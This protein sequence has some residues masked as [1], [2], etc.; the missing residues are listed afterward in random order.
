MQI[1]AGQNA[2]CS[3]NLS[4]LT[5]AVPVIMLIDYFVFLR[6]IMLY[7]LKDSSDLSCFILLKKALIK[8]NMLRYKGHC[9][10]IY[11]ME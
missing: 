2:P 1:E 5:G 11:D 9:N 6:V 3:R 4:R 7:S 10:E 8:L